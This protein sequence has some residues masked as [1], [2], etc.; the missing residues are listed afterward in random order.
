MGQCHSTDSR[1]ATSP[2]P[3][4]RR[5][6]GVPLNAAGP[7]VN[8]LRIAWALCT[9][10]YLPYNLLPTITADRPH[11]GSRLGTRPQLQV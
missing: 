10:D 2:E 8:V 7:K 1:R 3:D 5:V 11:Q 9:S 6:P 4:V